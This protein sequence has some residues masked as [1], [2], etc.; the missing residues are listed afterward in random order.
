MTKNQIVKKITNGNYKVSFTKTDGSNRVMNFNADD[1]EFKDSAAVV[2]D[3]RKQLIRSFRYA[4][5]NSLEKV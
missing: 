3:T 2:I 4:S 5:V 1:V